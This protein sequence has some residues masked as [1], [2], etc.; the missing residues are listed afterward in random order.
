MKPATTL[1]EQLKS[2]RERGLEFEDQATARFL[3]DNNYYR[4]SGYARYFQRDPGRGD[5]R[6][7]DINSFDRIRQAYEF[8]CELSKLLFG[9]LA[10]IEIVLRSR[11][12]YQMASAF[13]DPTAFRQEDT[14]VE[15]FTDWGTD[16]RAVLLSDIERDISRSKERFIRH[17]VLRGEGVPIWAAVEA[18]SFGTVSKMVEL[19]DDLAVVDKIG[20]SFG[21]PRST[22]SGTFHSLS[23][24]RNICA[25]HGRIWNRTPAR[26]VPVPTSLRAKMNGATVRSP[27]AWIVVMEQLVDT[28]RGNDYFSSDVGELLSD[29]PEM[30]DGLKRPRDT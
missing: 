24:L 10:D 28:V 16:L 18:L 2:L 30:I 6:Y 15:K 19:V 27:F 4:V 8:D 12:A 23:T 1:Q 17:H 13:D 25:H 5:N 14:Y 26:A 7:V 29:F 3:Y 21:L 11:L 22:V 9:G 20:K